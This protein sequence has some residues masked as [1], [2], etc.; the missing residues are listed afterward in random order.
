MTNLIFPLRT[1]EKLMEQ[2][3]LVTKTDNA[4]TDENA[5]SSQPEDVLL[6]SRTAEFKAKQEADPTLTDLRSQAD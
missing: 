1:D 5:S 2:W 4:V 3:P 6:T